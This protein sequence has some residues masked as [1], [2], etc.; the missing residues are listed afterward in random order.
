M[1]EKG[2]NHINWDDFTTTS[3]E[4]FQ[5]LVGKKEF[6]DVTLVLRD[7]SRIPSHQVILASSSTFFKKLLVEETLKN[8]LIFLRGVEVILLEPL[9]SF[10]YTGS[11]EVNEDLITQFEALAEDLGVDG[12]ADQIEALDTT[13]V[14]KSVDDKAEVAKIIAESLAETKKE[15]SLKNRSDNF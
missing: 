2:N 15:L 5:D 13:N 4:R 11:T 3:A 12:L 6:S 7:G 1:A 14:E 8:P 10:L 9:L